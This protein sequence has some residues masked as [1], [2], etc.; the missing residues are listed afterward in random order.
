MKR[1]LKLVVIASLFV[2][3]GTAAAN[4]VSRSCASVIASTDGGGL[5]AFIIRFAGA[6][7][8]TEYFAG[9]RPCG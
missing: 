5:V 8:W 7:W 2:L 6:K 9:G 1:A 4:F 3:P